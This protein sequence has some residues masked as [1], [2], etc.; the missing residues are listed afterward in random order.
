RRWHATEERRHFRSG[1]RE[2]EDVV[3]EEQ[4]VLTFFI[5][6]V[7][8]DGEAGQSDPK[9]RA[10]GLV[11][12]AIHERRLGLGEVLRDRKST[13]LNSSH[14]LHDALP[15]SADGMRPRSADTSD[16]ACVK[17]KMLSMKSS[18]S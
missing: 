11:H 14:S 15:I 8:G 16:P 18:T 5:P 12:L 1:L 17:R 9:S 4:H 3:D 2:A 10:R 13:R 6:E 7:L